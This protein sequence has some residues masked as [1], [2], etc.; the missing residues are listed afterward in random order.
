M[1]RFK[2]GSRELMVL[3]A[4]LVSMGHMGKQSTF[5]QKITKPLLSMHIVGSIDVDHMIK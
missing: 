3:T 1:I 4:N 2:N 5:Y